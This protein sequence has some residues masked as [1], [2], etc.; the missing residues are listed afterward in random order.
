VSLVAD[1]RIARIERGV[2]LAAISPTNTS[3]LA[4]ATSI[5]ADLRAWQEI[6]E[7]HSGNEYRS[8]THCA[9]TWRSLCPDRRLADAALDRLDALWGTDASPDSVPDGGGP[10]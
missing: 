7:R 3:P 9:G 1:P 8:C 6:A 4:Q 5:V 2:V 10:S